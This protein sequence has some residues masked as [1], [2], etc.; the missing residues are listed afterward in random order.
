[1]I[2]LDI[3]LHPPANP[4]DYFAPRDWPTLDANDE[5]LGGTNPVVVNLGVSHLILALGK[6]GMAYL[7]N[8]DDPGRDWRRARGR[9]GLQPV[10]YHRSSRISAPNGD[11]FVAFH[12]LGANCPG[13]VL[14]PALVVLRIQAQPSPGISTAWCGSLNG[15]GAP[16]V[17]TTDGSANPDCLD[18]WGRR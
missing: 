12:G 8:R 10:D 2:R 15:A 14:N 6:D 18:G 9:T 1:V 13:R 7:L 11:G 3:D 4:L 16:I 17:T 5:D